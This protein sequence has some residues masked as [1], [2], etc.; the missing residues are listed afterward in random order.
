MGVTDPDHML[1]KILDNVLVWKLRGE[2]A[3]RAAG[4][5]Y[6]IV[7]PGG[8]QDGPGGSGW[9]ENRPV[10]HN[11][12]QARRTVWPRR[13]T[14]STCARRA[15][16]LT[17]LSRRLPSGSRCPDPKWSLRKSRRGS[18]H[19][20]TGRPKSNAL[21]TLLAHRGLPMHIVPIDARSCREIL[22]RTL[23]SSV[24]EARPVAGLPLN[25]SI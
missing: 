14:R 25:S 24:S 23:K 5:P 19:C 12:A 22:P 10:G 21:K 7:R 17:I 15:G 18:D 16:A 2:D 20:G 8:L 13:Q 6:T 11:S 4:V 9:S 1:N 3:L